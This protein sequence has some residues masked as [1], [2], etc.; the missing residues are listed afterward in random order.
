MS[1]STTHL[2]PVDE[3]SAESFPAS[4]PPAF[5]GLHAG[6]PPRPHAAPTPRRGDPLRWLRR[7]AVAQGALYVASG[8]WPVVHR[9]SF[10]AVARRSRRPW[11]ART[12]GVALACAGVALMLGA[13]KAH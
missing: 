9:R 4:D 12:L 3:A 6:A 8:L 5:T 10:E 2:D 1:G 11:V 7:V 13:R